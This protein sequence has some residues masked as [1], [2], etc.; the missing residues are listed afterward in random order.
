MQFMPCSTYWP[1]LTFAVAKAEAA[2]SEYV[3]HSILILISS[4]AARQ[5]R[6]TFSFQFDTRKQ[7]HPKR[8]ATIT[9]KKKSCQYFVPLWLVVSKIKFI[10]ANQCKLAAVCS[11]QQL[12]YSSNLLK[13]KLKKKNKRI[14]WK[15]WILMPIF[16]FCFDSNFCQF[17]SRFLFIAGKSK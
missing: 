8:T 10:A 3:V 5:M 14:A 15:C 11:K 17:L 6:S 1:T 9:S 2:W 12:S 7:D 4:S 13:A 16:F